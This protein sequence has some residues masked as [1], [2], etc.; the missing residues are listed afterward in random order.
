[1]AGWLLAYYGFHANIVQNANTQNGIRMMVSIYPAIGALV[2]GLFML[3]YPLKESFLTN[4]EAD[5]AA[6]PVASENNPSTNA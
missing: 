3:I 5:L 1:M 6:R 2:S 4:I